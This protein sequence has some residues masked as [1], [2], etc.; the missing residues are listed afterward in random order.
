MA[1]HR[2]LRR[3][4]ETY[5]R[6]LTA[7]PRTDVLRLNLVDGFAG[8]GVYVDPMTNLRHP[9]SPAIL[10]DAVRSAEAATN[11]GRAKPLR[12]DARFFFVDDDPAAIACL[13]VVLGQR[14]TWSQEVGNV[15]VIPGRFEEHL[16]DIV[17]KIASRSGTA[18]RTIFVLDQYGY[19]AAPP[20]LLRRIFERLPRAEVFLTLAVGW[21]ASYLGD[22]RA[23]ALKLGIARDVLDRLADG[24]DDGPSLDEPSTRATLMKLQ[25]LL[26]DVF[27]T[28]IGSTYYTPFFIVSR[29]SNRCYW[30]L[31]MANSHRA[32]DVVKALHWEVENHFDHFG[33]EGLG[34]LGYDPA[35][36]PEVTGQP[37]LPFCFNDA[38]RSRTR[39][40]LAQTLATRIDRSF[41]DG[42]T[43][44]GLYAHVCNETPADRAILRQTVSDLCSE[45][46][47]KKHGAKGER[48][49][50]STTLRGDDVIRVPRQSRFMFPHR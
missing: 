42:V 27:T 15:H 43:L 28:G 4:V 6:V 33:G 20:P 22:L 14:E 44:D 45:G 16:D 36:D 17:D 47:L 40:A 48:R 13:K 39:T 11:V 9:G 34:M 26:K 3:Y 35:K 46:E 38:A 29:E 7:D 10:L 37:L 18:K 21:A 2:I 5:I 8:G 30:F 23:V 25:I 49:A 19:T 31:H 50:A 12:V 1:K 41:P 32:N 24:G